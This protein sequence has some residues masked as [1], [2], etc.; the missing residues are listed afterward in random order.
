MVS[1]L[2]G[3]TNYGLVRNNG[4]WAASTK[5]GTPTLFGVDVFGSVIN[6]T[7]QTLAKHD[8]LGSV[9]QPDRC[10]RDERARFGYRGELTVLGDTYLRARNYQNTT[11]TFTTVDPL[12]DVAATSTSGS[13]PLL[14]QRPDQPP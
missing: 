1:T 2:D 13:V 3:E 4:T 6:S 14:V 7:G 5:G 11:G 9:R 8:W 12:N 10:D